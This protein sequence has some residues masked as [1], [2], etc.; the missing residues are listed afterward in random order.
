MAAALLN[1]CGSEEETNFGE[2]T[3]NG[4]TIGF[5]AEQM[6]FGGKTTRSSGEQTTANFS[7][8]SVFAYKTTGDWTTAATPGFMYNQRVTKSAGTWT[9]SPTQYWPKEGYDY[10]V[11]FFAISPMPSA[12]NGITPS[13]A[14]EAGYPSFTVTPPASPSAQADFCMATPVMNATYTDPDGNSTDTD[15]TDG[16]VKFTFAHVM[17]KL[18]FSAKYVSNE[19]LYF[20][21]KEIKIKNI[22][23]G[24][25][26]RFNASSFTWDTPDPVA[27]T[28]IYTLSAVDGTL[29]K[30]RKSTRLNSS[31]WKQ[32]RM[33]SSA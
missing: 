26:L 14:N 8:M 10:K 27:N 7:E 20:F 32:S 2:G 4:Y 25:T 12:A 33:P 9:Y 11:S 19:E 15:D 16:K 30:D 1:S 5:A 29:E 17:S 21:I 22:I 6:D 31:H 3:D 18:T 24:N 13:A 23:A 28:G